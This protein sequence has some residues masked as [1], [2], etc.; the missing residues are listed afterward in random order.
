MQSKRAPEALAAT[1]P[2]GGVP[3]HL[4]KRVLRKASFLDKVRSS[5]QAPRAKAGK[6][7]LRCIA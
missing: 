3:V 1:A 5:Q 7:N 4:R 6:K 2:A